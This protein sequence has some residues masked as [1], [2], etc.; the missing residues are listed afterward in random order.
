MNMI[1]I[2]RIRTKLGLL[3]GLV[4]VT[5]VASVIIG[6]TL[7]RH[8]TTDEAV[9]KLPAVARSAP[10]IAQVLNKQVVAGRLNRDQVLARLRDDIYTMRFDRRIGYVLDPGAIRGRP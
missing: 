1:G 5:V 6:A 9:D 3:P 2:F 7:M 8:R 10:G 4:F